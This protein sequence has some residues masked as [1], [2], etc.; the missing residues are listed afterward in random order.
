MSNDNKK[1]AEANVMHISWKF[2][3]HPSYRIWGDFEYVWQISAIMRTN[4][5]QQFGQIL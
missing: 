5:N 2:Q 3:F 1:N 4:Q